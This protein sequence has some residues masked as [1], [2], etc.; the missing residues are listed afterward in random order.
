MRGREVGVNGVQVLND[1]GDVQGGLR[2]R[3]QRGHVGYGA[4][5]AGG[6]GA[7]R[8]RVH[9]QQLRGADEDDQDNAEQR[10][11]NP[12]GL[13]AGGAARRGHHHS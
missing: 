13:A 1:I 8:T 4:E 2:E 9:V 12:E 5:R 7:L 3:G 6:V 10:Q 11:Q